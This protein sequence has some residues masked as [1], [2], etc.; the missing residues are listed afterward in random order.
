M[1]GVS[2]AGPPWFLKA[3]ALHAIVR[4]E[5]GGSRDSPRAK[6]GSSKGAPSNVW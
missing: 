4:T 3:N 2:V 1:R 6:A 5:V